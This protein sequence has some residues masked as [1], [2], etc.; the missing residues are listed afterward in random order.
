[1]KSSPS[2]NPIAL[3][4]TVT[5]RRVLYKKSYEVDEVDFVVPRLGVLFWRIFGISF[6]RRKDH[7][8]VVIVITEQILNVCIDGGDVLNRRNLRLDMTYWSWPLLSIFFHRVFFV[9]MLVLSVLPMSSETSCTTIVR[10]Y[11]CVVIRKWEYWELE[12]FSFK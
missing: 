6:L 1:M 3:L 4:E 11:R 5:S 8:T 7:D 10:Q 12:K 2:K 9:R